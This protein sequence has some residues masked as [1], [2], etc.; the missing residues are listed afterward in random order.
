[1]DS[2]GLGGAVV[3]FCD[4][5]N[6]HWGSVKCGHFCMSLAADCFSRGILLRGV[7][8]LFLLWFCAG[9]KELNITPVL[10]KIQ[11]YKKNWIQHVNRMPRNRLPRL[12]KTTPQEAEGTK[13]D[14]WRDS[15]TR[16]IG[17]GQQVAQLLDSYMMMMMI[18][19]WNYIFCLCTWWPSPTQCDWHNQETCS[20]KLAWECIINLDN[21]FY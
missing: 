12:I 11:E 21:K 9:A 5:G 7:S 2:S 16:E 1:V 6:K 17:T 3:S 19:C 10:D 18:L 13:E 4:D 20:Q 15:W 14:H 8:T